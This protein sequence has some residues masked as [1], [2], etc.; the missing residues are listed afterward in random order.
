[1]LVHVSAE[2][3]RSVATFIVRITREPH[4]RL[5]G[6]VE[7]VRTGEKWPFAGTDGIGGLIERMLALDHDQGRRRRPKE[8]R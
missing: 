2:A 1:M 5:Q 4:G 3:S 7:R 6:T 8:E